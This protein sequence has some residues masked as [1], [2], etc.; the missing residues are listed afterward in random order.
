MYRHV[1]PLPA[2]SQG[3][4]VEFDVTYLSAFTAPIAPGTINLAA[5][6]LLLYSGSPKAPSSVNLRTVAVALGSQV[7]LEGGPARPMV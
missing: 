1:L 3:N 6:A 4:L 2:P 5:H 7:G